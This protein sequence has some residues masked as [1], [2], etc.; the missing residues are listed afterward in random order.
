[1]DGT[2]L[3][4][5]VRGQAVCLAVEGLGRNPTDRGRSGSVDTR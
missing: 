4:A 3:P 2:W 5:P 1:M